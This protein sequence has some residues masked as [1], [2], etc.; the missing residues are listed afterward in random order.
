MRFEIDDGRF[1]AGFTTRLGGVSEEK[2]ISLNLGDH[3]GDEPKNVAKNREILAS[4][5][6]IDA[7]RLKFMK[8]I[9]SNRV[10]I[11]RKIDDEIPP[12]D[13][14]VTNLKGVAL[15]VMVADCSPILLIDKKR[16]VIA[17]VHAGRAGVL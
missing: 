12:C 16:D 9:H 10:E 5:L 4:K 2:F 14:L 8:Q 15:C 13:G 11:L 3:V 17:A 6:G 7:S 1:S